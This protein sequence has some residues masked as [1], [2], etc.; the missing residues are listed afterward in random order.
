MLWTSEGPKRTFYKVNLDGFSFSNGADAQW[1]F[2]SGWTRSNY[3]STE[4]PLKGAGNSEFETFG[5]EN[6][7][8]KAHVY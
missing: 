6:C 7:R 3:I 2:L 8:T 5:N 4:A 1:E